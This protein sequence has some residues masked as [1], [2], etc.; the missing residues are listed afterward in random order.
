MDMGFCTR[1]EQ[2]EYFSEIEV[3]TRK[4]PGKILEENHALVN[5]F[6]DEYGFKEGVIVILKGMGRHHPKIGYAFFSEVPNTPVFHE[7]L[8]ECPAYKDKIKEG[9]LLPVPSGVDVVERTISE[10]SRARLITLAIER[11]N[12]QSWDY[13]SSRDIVLGQADADLRADVLQIGDYP[14]LGCDTIYDPKRASNLRHELRKAEYRAFR[15]FK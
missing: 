10:E 4:K 11:A 9:E 15:Y 14:Y 13:Y 5:Y 3:S 6:R 8:N 7:Y 2:T 12:Y 1:D